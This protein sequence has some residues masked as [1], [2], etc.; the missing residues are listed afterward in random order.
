[1]GADLL[2]RREAL[3]AAGVLAAGCMAAPLL[4]LAGCGGAGAGAESGQGSSATAGYA[5]DTEVK[6]YPV[7]CKLYVDS[8]VSWN[9]RGTTSQ[10][11]GN[12]HLEHYINWYRAQDGRGQ[13]DIEVTYVEP[14]DLAGYAKS[15][16]PEGD[17]V[18]ATEQTVAAAA[19]A[20]TAE[21]GEGGYLV[22]SLSQQLGDDCVLVRAKGTDAELPPADTID[23]QDTPD[24]QINRFQQLPSFEGKVAVADPATTTEGYNANNALWKAGLY[25]GPFEGGGDYDEKVAGKLVFYPDQ[26]SAMAALAAGE[27]SLAFALLSAVNAGRFP[28]VELLYQPQGSFVGYS[29]AAIAGAGEPGVA[30]DFFEAVTHCSW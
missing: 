24:G 30:R 22:R 4:G 29:A 14:A 20:G 18:I 8:D 21:G 19:E 12:N 15:G 2:T 11:G 7:T 3:A 9:Q 26:E 5:A 1:M 10:W 25:E 6:D 17:G 28:D 23:G 13:V 27:C 16:F